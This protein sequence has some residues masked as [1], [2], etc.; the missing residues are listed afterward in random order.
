[1]YFDL[2][3]VFMY[4]NL[5]F[6][7]E[8]RVDSEGLYNTL[9]QSGFIDIV[10]ENI[11]EKEELW[12]Y[13]KMI[14][15]KIVNKQNNLIGLISGLIEELPNKVNEAKE[16]LAEMDPEFVKTLTTGSFAGMLGSFLGKEET[17]DIK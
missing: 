2:H 11:D 6:D 3:L 17:K 12:N 13:I 4:T 14:E 8:D 5:V 15:N 9:K 1:M 16:K 10:K 7:A